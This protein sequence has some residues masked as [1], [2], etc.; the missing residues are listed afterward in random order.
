M[1]QEIWKD[2]CGYEG[3]YQISNLGR[4]KSLKRIIECYNGKLFSI[5][6]KILKSS[7]GGTSPYLIVNLCRK[8]KRK[9]ALVHRLVAESFIGKIPSKYEVNHKNGI[10]SDNREDNLE[11]C[12]HQKNID[13]S[14]YF[15]LKNDYGEKSNNAKLTNKEANIIRVRWKNG[16]MQKTL[17]TEFSV[18]KQTICNIIHNKSYYK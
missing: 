17:A 12:S 13:H 14:I 11:I 16:E 8:G 10:V 6:S 5:N 1:T 4:V 18:S 9:H 3:I 15:G 2:I 7:P